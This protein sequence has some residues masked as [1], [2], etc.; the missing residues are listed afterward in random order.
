MDLYGYANDL[1]LIGQCNFQVVE[2]EK[3]VSYQQEQ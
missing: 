3:E 2:A 1:E